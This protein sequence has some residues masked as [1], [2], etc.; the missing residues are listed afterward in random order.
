MRLLAKCLVLAIA[1]CLTTTSVHSQ[2]LTD[3]DVSKIVAAM[4]KVTP[5]S[6]NTNMA[7]DLVMPFLFFMTLSVAPGLYLMKQHEDRKTHVLF[8]RFFVVMSVASMA[9]ST[10]GGWFQ[11]W[12]SFD[13]TW[14]QDSMT[15]SDVHWRYYVVTIFHWIS[16][17]AYGAEA[18][19]IQTLD[20]SAISNSAL[21][22]ST[23]TQ[24]VFS[25]MS[26]GYIWYYFS[27]AA[28]QFY[29][30]ALLLSAYF[31]VG[32]WYRVDYDA[33]KAE[34]NSEYEAGAREFLTMGR[35]PVMMP[36]F[37]AGITIPPV[38]KS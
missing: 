30:P 31:A 12:K 38:P 8:H 37:G 32:L 28:A 22:I 2:P 20:R 5:P 25:G 36:G 7:N 35:K 6:T 10:G 4:V 24:M 16:V 17:F 3:A 1:L 23:I 19:A 21:F 11:F 27:V 26:M 13:P 14:V 34:A 18:I 33:S 9:L 29:W 15:M